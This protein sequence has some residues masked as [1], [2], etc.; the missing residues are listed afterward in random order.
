[1]HHLRMR[2]R[3]RGEIA[4]HRSQAGWEVWL[5]KPL[6]YTQSNCLLPSTQTDVYLFLSLV[7]STTNSMYTHYNLNIIS[8]FILVIHYELTLCVCAPEAKQAPNLILS[9]ILC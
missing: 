9:K 1:M 3:E 6:G 5:N 7:Q 4:F 2:M 8:L